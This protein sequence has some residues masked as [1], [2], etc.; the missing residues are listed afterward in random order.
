MKKRD[1]VTYGYK[2]KKKDQIEDTLSLMVIIQEMK[3]VIWVQVLVAAVCIS[4]RAN[5]LR[6]GMNPPTLGK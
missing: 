6:T 5:T 4:L 2:D 1:N 3:S